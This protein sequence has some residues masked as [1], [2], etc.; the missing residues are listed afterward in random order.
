MNKSK[1]EING[2]TAY[3]YIYNG[4]YYITKTGTLYSIYVK[5]GQGK[6]D[7]NRIHKVAY[8]QDKDGYYRVVLSNNGEKKHIKIHQIVVNQFLGGCK[9]GFVI[10]HKDGNKHNNNVDNL[11]VVTGLENIQHAW[12]TGLNSKDKNPNRISVDVYDNMADIMYHFASLQETHDIIKD[13][14]IRYINQLRNNDVPFYAHMFKKVVYG[15]GRFDYCVECYRNGILYKT[16][17]NIKDA[18]KE[19]GKPS[20]TISG[21]FKAKYPKRLN[22]YTITFPNVSTIESSL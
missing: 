15:S 8:G 12:N 4:N 17:D 19:F 10:N 5:G 6:T 14:P 20:N 1:I 13:I 21:A 3:Q 16:F 11:E 18:G 9:D 7:I 2:E 22:R